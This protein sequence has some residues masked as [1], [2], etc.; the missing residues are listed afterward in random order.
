GDFSAV[1]ALEVEAN[2]TNVDIPSNVD[3][4]QGDTVDVEATV[5]DSLGNPVP[6]VSVAITETNPNISLREDD[7]SDGQAT[8]VT[9][10]SGKVV[11]GVNASS[12]A[13]A[14]TYS[15]DLSVQTVSVTLDINVR[16]APVSSS[17]TPISLVPGD[18]LEWAVTVYDGNANPVPGVVV[19]GTTSLTGQLVVGTDDA[20]PE[21]VDLVTNGDGQVIFPLRA[22]ADLLGP[23]TYSSALTV[24]VQGLDPQ[25]YDIEVETRIFSVVYDSG[26]YQVNQGA[27]ITVGA[28]A[29]D[30]LGDP[31]DLTTVPA[32]ADRQIVYTSFDSGV[33]ISPSL[34]VPASDGTFSFDID[35]GVDAQG[36]FLPISAEGTYLD[37]AVP[38]VEILQVVDDLVPIQDPVSIS[39]GD[40]GAVGFVLRDTG[41]G[42]IPDRIVDVSV[43]DPDVELR[44]ELKWDPILWYRMNDTGPAISDSSG[45]GNDGASSGLTFGQTGALVGETDDAAEFGNAAYVDTGVDAASSLDKNFTIQLWVRPNAGGSGTEDILWAGNSPQALYLARDA[46]SGELKVG[47]GTFEADTGVTVPDGVWSHVAL[48]VVDDPFDAGF[49]GLFVYVNGIREY[50]TSNSGIGDPR[51]SSNLLIGNTSGGFDGRI[52]EVVVLAEAIPGSDVSTVYHTGVSGSPSLTKAVTDGYGQAWTIAVLSGTAGPTETVNGNYQ[53]LSSSHD[54]SL[55][56]TAS[57]LTPISD[58]VTI[59]SSSRGELGFTLEDAGH[60]GLPGETVDIMS[61]GPDVELRPELRGNPIGWYRFDESGSAHTSTSATHDVDILT[62][63]GDASGGHS[64]VVAGGAAYCWGDGSNGRLGNGSTAD[65][66]V[67]V[68]VDTSGV[69]SGKTVTAI[70]AGHENSCAVADGEVFC[71][72]AGA[73]GALGTGSTA[74]SSV[75]VAVDTSGVLS[76]KTVTNI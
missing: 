71:W 19:T 73:S 4:P 75:P 67:P 52:D 12:T 8:L 59:N 60:V 34:I 21:T 62:S 38:L 40:S 28:T 56:V 39:A 33:T 54:I 42:G 22:K 20:D 23:G 64:C 11:V 45:N 31:V 44:P 15:L 1:G 30:N 68:A 35:A 49:D 61:P 6:G 46:S 18:V 74:D 13:P 66:S 57:Y 37:G 65:S 17:A 48:E 27:L 32:G 25:T 50:Q 41:G 69:L 3:V 43:S 76:G 72:G 2:A 29:V 16:S 63:S 70:A 53:T 5:T 51:P 47:V 24:E 36:G 58:P 10:S 9:D 55:A 26:S 7:D 14:G